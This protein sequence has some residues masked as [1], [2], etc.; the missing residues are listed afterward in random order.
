MLINRD[1]RC[2]VTDTV[3]KVVDK[4]AKKPKKFAI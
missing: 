2:E 4:L 1:I 3:V